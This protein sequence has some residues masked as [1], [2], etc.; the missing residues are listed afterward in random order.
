MVR[1]RPEAPKNIVYGGVPKWPKG[2]DCKSVSSAFDGS[3]PSS[4]TKNKRGCYYNLFYFYP[5]GLNNKEAMKPKIIAAEIPALV[6]SNIPVKTP[7]IPLASY[8]FQAPLNKELPKL[9]MGIVAPEI[10]R[11]SCRE[12]V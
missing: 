5:L 11:A 7:M 4:S 10:G 12:R 9:H 8:S 6:T 3:N 1:F 2:A